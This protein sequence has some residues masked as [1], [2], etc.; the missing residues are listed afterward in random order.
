MPGAGAGGE[1]LIVDDDLQEL[2][3]I[4]AG[5]REEVTRQG[6]YGCLIVLYK[7]RA[8]ELFGCSKIICFLGAIQPL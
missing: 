2:S 5:R 4:D 8:S 3:R 6:R 1:N 7:L